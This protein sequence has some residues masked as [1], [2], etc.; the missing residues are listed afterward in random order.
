MS[1][2]FDPT[3]HLPLKPVVFQILLALAEEPLH[4]YGVIQAV[5]SES[6]HLIRLETGPFY[7]HLRKLL[8]AELVT[9]TTDRPQGN[10]RRG[11]Y[12][13]LTDRGRRVV[14]AECSRL[15]DLVSATRRMGLAGD[16]SS[17]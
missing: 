7:R 1:R 6:R 12:Y 11:A 13:E 2:D 5:R 14:T 3:S 9:E 8:D 10:A 16:A 15:V 4:G 17:T